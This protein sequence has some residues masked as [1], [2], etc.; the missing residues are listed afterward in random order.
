MNRKKQR[1][2]EIFKQMSPNTC[3]C[4]SPKQL[5]RKIIPMRLKT[6]TIFQRWQSFKFS[7]STQKRKAKNW[8]G[9]FPKSVK[10]A[11]SILEV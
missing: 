9:Y 2:N 3:L 1:L 6:V 5:T 11:K 7:H 10:N 8:Q 4:E